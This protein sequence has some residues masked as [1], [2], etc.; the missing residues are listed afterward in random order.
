MTIVPSQ[1][2]AGGQQA[3]TAALAERISRAATLSPL[4]GSPATGA[5]LPMYN[6]ELNQTMLP[7]PLSAAR[8]VGWRYPVIGGPEP[9]LAHL[10]AEQGDSE[11]EGL[12]RGYLPRRLI[13]AAEVAQ[14]ALGDSDERYEARLLQIPA[15]RI[16]ALW[17]KGTN[18]DRFVL[19]TDGRT[20]PTAGPPPPVIDDIRPV[21]AAARGPDAPRAAPVGTGPSN[22]E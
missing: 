18:D 5:P 7:D 17:M 4:G 16:I 15:L 14:E 13:E 19:L 20:P 12:T 2:P 9:G 8:L 22:A 3:I 21:I 1:P 10:S 11:Y 6:V